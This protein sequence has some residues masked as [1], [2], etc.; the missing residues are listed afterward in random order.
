MGNELGNETGVELL[1]LP[2]VTS[3]PNFALTRNGYFITEFRRNL[4]LKVGVCEFSPISR[5]IRVEL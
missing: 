3:P 4:A 1:L 5:R 2:P